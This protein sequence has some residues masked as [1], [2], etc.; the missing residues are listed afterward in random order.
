ML[1]QDTSFHKFKAA[2]EVGDFFY[3]RLQVSGSGHRLRHCNAPQGT[4][5]LIY[6]YPCTQFCEA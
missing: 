1:P 6:L 5:D 4:L 3:P 2:H